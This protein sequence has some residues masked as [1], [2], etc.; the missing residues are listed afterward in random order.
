MGYTN[1]GDDMSVLKIMIQ[2]EKMRNDYMR[3]HYEDEIDK[4][5]KGTIVKKKIGNHEYSYLKYRNDKKTVTDYIGKDVDRVED[6]KYN[7]EKRK[8]CKKML[9]VL[10]EESNII[11]KILEEV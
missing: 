3:Q 7:I 6:I 9:E 4:L 10:V 8:H 5:P 2:K 1:I 11:E